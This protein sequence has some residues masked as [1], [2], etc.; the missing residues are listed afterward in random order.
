MWPDDGNFKI[1]TPEP[2]SFYPHKVM[3]LIYPIT[4][5]WDKEYIDTSFWEIDRARILSVPLGT[6]SAEDKLMWHY[7]KDGCFSVRSCYQFLL[8]LHSYSE[9]QERGTTSGLEAQNWDVIWKL[10]I[11]PKIIMF[12][13]RAYAGILPLK[14]ELFQRHIVCSPYCSGFDFAVE[15]I[16]HVLLECR[17]MQDLWRDPHFHLN[18]IDSSASMRFILLWLKRSLPPIFSW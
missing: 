8:Q 18:P 12:L 17:G 9:S 14:V 2:A 11:P 3:D 6:T 4:G 5:T 15:S 1:I 7:S 10:R 16:A 13:W